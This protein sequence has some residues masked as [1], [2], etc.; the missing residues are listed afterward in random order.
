[1][2]RI[3]FFLLILTSLFWTGCGNA[4]TGEMAEAGRI[5]DDLSISRAMAAKTM[6]LTFYTKEELKGLEKVAEFPDVPQ[7]D[8]FYPY[9]N[10]A[11]Q[12]GLLSG[13]EDGNFYPEKDLTLIQA[14]A[15][16]DR[17]APDYDSRMVL[18]ES[19]QNMPVAYSL[20]IQLLQTA[21]EAREEEL[22]SY[23][24]TEENRVLL[25]A[26][27][28]GGM[29]DNGYYGGAGLDLKPFEN[30]ALRY[31]AKDGEIL[32]LLEVTDTAPTIENIYC[33]A[34][35]G[36]IRMETGAG[37]VTRPYTGQA[38]EGIC[39]VTLSEGKA[40][41]AVQAAELGLCTVKRVNGQE[42]YLAEQGLLSWADDFRIY[43][44][45]GTEWTSQKVSKLICGT[46]G[47]NYYLKDG[48]VAG[49][50]ITQT[51]QPENIRVLVGGAGQTKVT[52]SVEGGFTLKSSDAEKT[53]SNGEQAVLTADLPWFDSGIVKAAPVG[54]SPVSVTFSDGTK[55]Q[56]FGTVELERRQD[57]ISVI[58]ELPLETYLRGVVPHEMPVDFGE[59]ALEAQAITARSYAYNQFYA[60]SYCGYGAHLTDTVASQVYL[61]ADTAELSDGAIKATAGKCLTAE[62]EV[63]TTYFYSTSCGYGADAKEV[64]SADGTF[65]EESKPYL[66]GGIHGIS[67][68]KPHTEEE[69]LAFWQDWEIKGYDDT[70][71]WYRWKTYFGA[72]QLTEITSTKL[73]EAAKS[74]PAHV[75]VLQEDG[76]WKAQ[77]PNDLGR[78]TGISVAKRGESGVMEVLRLDYEKGSV[79]VK[80]EYTIRQVLSPTKMTVGD[81][82]Y[83]QRKDG[84]SL[85]GNT[86]LPSGFFAV[87]EMKNAEGKLT[88]V[89][90]YGGGNGHGVGMSQYGAKG[91]AEDGK[92]AEEILEHYYTGTT[93]QQVI[94]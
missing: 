68:E 61:G 56:Y 55:R 11:V 38:V 57:G 34:S 85:T 86:L 54:D 79:Q 72:G 33:T 36:T 4:V 63:V 13:D 66:A 75:E 87:K 53:F 27:E 94:A 92:T 62:N 90:L 28:S 10:G 93:V 8:P 82:I 9:I 81:P 76:S 49:A 78:L 30:T 29:F 1:M 32:A 89:A 77:T 6:A 39:D 73:K 24:I 50:I 26:E 35:G 20:W 65:T 5:G 47:A 44:A 74:H 31:W 48:K 69:W 88:G 7:T 21:L 43:D 16:L 84:A 45:T 71:P 58:N 37:S 12:L 2:K 83:L 15:L 67:A 17:L 42:I 46:K 25:T 23:D 91:M 59:T 70:S 41:E 22:S 52:I 14:Q 51:V 19:N 80:T 3:C 40:T 64:W 60:N 18:D